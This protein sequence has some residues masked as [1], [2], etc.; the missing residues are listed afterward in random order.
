MDL[1]VVKS[2]LTYNKDNNNDNGDGKMRAGWKRIPGS[3][4]DLFTGILR[5]KIEQNQVIRMKEY[6]CLSP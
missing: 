6:L 4:S 2:S 5:A 1:T 3:F